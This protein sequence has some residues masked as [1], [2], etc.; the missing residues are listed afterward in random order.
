MADQ[1]GKKYTL[2]RSQKKLLE[3]TYYQRKYFY[4]DGQLYR[5]VKVDRPA[6]VCRAWSYI[7]QRLVTFVWSDIRRMTQQAFDTEEVC[8][9]LNRTKQ[10]L[11]D[12]LRKGAI[13]PP[14]KIG[15]NPNPSGEPRLDFGRYKWSEDDV[16]ALHEHY[17]TVGVG[18]PRKDGILFSAPRIP[19]RLELIAM[20]KQQQMYYVRDADG[21]FV[22]IFEQP[23][24][25]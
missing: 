22:P 11:F 14:Y 9:L 2:R 3:R 10:N 7:D 13:N 18:R 24:W 21:N 4:L 16:L 25:T 12:H 6:N 5:I 1:E 20:M 23:D 19:S 17:L 15:T 8:V